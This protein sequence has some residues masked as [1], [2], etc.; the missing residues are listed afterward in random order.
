MY[1]VLQLYYSFS[2]APP[3]L[4][5]EEIEAQ[6]GEA[7]AQDLYPDSELIIL[8]LYHKHPEEEQPQVLRTRGDGGHRLAVSWIS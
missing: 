3:H 4:T 6:R 7:T 8:P 1:Q 2:L 5:Q